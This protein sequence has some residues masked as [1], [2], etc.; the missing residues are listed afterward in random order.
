MS[1][2]RKSNCY[3]NAVVE[4]YFHTLKTEM[5]RFESFQSREEATIKILEYIELYY[6]RQRSYSSIG[7][8]SPAEFENKL[9]CKLVA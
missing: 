1:M 5:A 8:C 6:N 2:S 7:Y 3:D 9:K 4:S